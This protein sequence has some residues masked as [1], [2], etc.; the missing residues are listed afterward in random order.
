MSNAPFWEAA[1]AQSDA[2]DTFGPPAEELARVVSLLPP[3]ASVLDL[4]CG[5]GRNALYLAGRGCKVTAVDI[6]AAGIGKLKRMAHAA[7]LQV[8]AEVHDM[9]GYAFEQSYDLVVA[10]GSLHLIE[11][12]HWAP[13][14]RR[15][16]A[17]TSDGGWNVVVVFTNALPPPDDL[18]E[19]H[20]GLFREGEL[21]EFY[22][23][24]DVLLKESYVLE[25]E[26]PGDIRHRHPV[27][28]LVARKGPGKAVARHDI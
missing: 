19:F 26:H 7:G 4:G 28:R 5:E 20:L 6:S 8:T 13:L 18:K 23:G 2:A 1:Y 24:W 14:L 17:H 21:F 12:E 16:K 9:R 3:G 15:V 27:N 22:D 25:D 10:H 11:R